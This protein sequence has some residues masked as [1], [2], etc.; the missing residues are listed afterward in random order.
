MNSSL[1]PLLPALDNPAVF[2]VVA[3]L[4]IALA[5]A[6]AAARFFRPSAPTTLR[7]LV[8]ARRATA[9]TTWILLTF[10]LAVAAAAVTF[11]GGVGGSLL[12]ALLGI[13][14]FLVAFPLLTI[15]LWAWSRGRVWADWLTLALVTGLCTVVATTQ[16]LWICEPL[17]WSGFSAAQM[18]TAR[19]YAEGSQGAIRDTGVAASWY[20]QAALNGNEE[21]VS[22]LMVVTRNKL[23]QRRHLEK[24]ALAGNAAAMYHLFVLLGPP[25]GLRW[26]EMAIEMRQAD[27][28][29]QKSAY[30]RSGEHGFSVDVELADSLLKEAAEAGSPAA[31]AD[32]SLA[33]ESGQRPFGYSRPSSLFWEKRVDDQWP[34]YGRWL[35]RLDRQRKLRDRISQGDAAAMLELAHDYKSRARKDP[36]YEFDVREW[37]ARAAEARS[38]EAQFEIAHIHFRRADAT[39]DEMA[40]ARRWLTA[41]ADQQHRYALSNISYYLTNGQHGFQIDLERARDYTRTLLTLL[42]NESRPHRRDLE[43]AEA[44]LDQI[45]IQLQQQLA[46]ED[47]MDDLQVRS[48]AGDADALYRLYEKHISDR[49]RGDW[50][51]A[52]SLLLAAAQQGHVEAR[53]R[54][55]SRT[56]SQP[57]TSAEEARAYEWMQDTA[58]QGHRGALVAMARIHLRGLP[59]YDI[60][61]NPETARQLL[62]SALAGL[63]GDVVYSRRN[64]TMTVSTRRESVERLLAGIEGASAP[65]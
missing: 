15:W 29:Y 25:E 59:E 43:L 31:A 63:E 46:W 36:V 8:V 57:R 55:A 58:A 34:G 41:A 51:T 32:L 26:L 53:Y 4:L 56:L 47:G 27:A 22:R 61:K 21:A 3:V 39:A 7:R 54:I 64:G 14:T 45:E 19:L 42:S 16:R 12:I 65:P 11:A 20:G 24:A 38:T 35:P 13:L 6:S 23:T 52:Q 9:I 33:Y 5:A 10:W 17:A 50:T 1:E 48:A 2:A 40:D 28:L 44:R 18:C 49:E 30:L 37:L 60:E 62:E